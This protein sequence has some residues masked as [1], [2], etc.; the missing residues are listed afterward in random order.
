[1]AK[2]KVDLVQEDEV[3]VKR[4]FHDAHSKGR[5][6][7]Q[8]ESRINQKWDSFEDWDTDPIETFQKFNKRSRR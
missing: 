3:Q 5:E 2:S 7:Q 8:I 4:T 1:M 6:K